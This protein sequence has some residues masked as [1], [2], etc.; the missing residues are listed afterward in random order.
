[1]REAYVKA[2]LRSLVIEK[3]EIGFERL[4]GFS[5]GFISLPSD[6]QK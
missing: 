6:W 5:H 1:M 2:L 3:L 4:R